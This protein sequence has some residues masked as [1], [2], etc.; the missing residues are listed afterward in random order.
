MKEKFL[1]STI[2]FL[3]RYNSYSENDIKKLRYGLEGLYLTIT[4]MIIVLVLAL[5]LGIINE[6]LVVIVLF[7]II[8]YFGFGFHAEKSSHCLLLSI[9]NFIGIPLIFINI[10]ISLNTKLIIAG[11]CIFNYLIFAPADTVK[12]PLPNKKKRIIRKI[13]TVSVGVAYIIAIILFNG[14]HITKLILCSLIIQT[15]VLSPITYKLFKQPYNNYK[16][17]S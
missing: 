14:S 10:D 17:L 5:I 12:R 16:K 6:V 13:L 11:I 8:R 1:N 7:N 9:I 2:V 3:K 15:I 4:K